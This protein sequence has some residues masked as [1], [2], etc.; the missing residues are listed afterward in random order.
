MTS[1]VEEVKPVDVQALRDIAAMGGHVGVGG[2]LLTQLLDELDRW[3]RALSDTR[4]TAST[5]LA[6]NPTKEQMR[7]TLARIAGHE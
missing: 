6:L 3:K 7:R 2:K 1:A 5:C 4:G